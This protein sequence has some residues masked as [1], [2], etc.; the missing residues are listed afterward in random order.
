[1]RISEQYRLHVCYASDRTTGMKGGIYRYGFILRR[2]RWDGKGN[3]TVSGL[4]IRISGDLD[5]N[6]DLDLGLDLDFGSM[7]AWVVLIARGVREGRWNGSG[8]SRKQHGLGRRGFL[9]LF[10]YDRTELIDVRVMSVGTGVYV[11]ALGGFF[12]RCWSMGKDE[13]GSGF[14]GRPVSQ[15]I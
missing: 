10:F 8:Y 1:M 4:Q 12:G 5:L 6:L 9:T 15:K 3:S 11:V 2:W 13:M 14:P 7:R